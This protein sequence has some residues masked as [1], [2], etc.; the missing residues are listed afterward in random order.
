[1]S[2]VTLPDWRRQVSERL[3]ALRDL[4]QDRFFADRLSMVLVVVAFI[5]NSLN[6]LLLVLKLHVT[7]IPVP[8]HYSTL[9]G[10]DEL[11][12]W[13]DHYSIGVFAVAAT[14]I[15]LVL[16]RQSF[17]RS[18]ISSFY[19]LMGSVVVAFLCLVISNAFSMVS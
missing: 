1:M 2:T 9:S 19:L 5:I 4:R 18:R 16:A 17:S 11:G 14:L 3:G 8:V 13:Y 7:D 6:W 15:N 10:F 12:R